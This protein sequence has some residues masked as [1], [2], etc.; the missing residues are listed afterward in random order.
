L[1]KLF[2]LFYRALGYQWEICSEKTI[3]RLGCFSRNVFAAAEENLVMCCF[4]RNVMC[5][6]LLGNVISVAKIFR[7]PRI[8]EE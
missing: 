1:V 8:A 2:L 5:H 3:D 4:E 7:Q 6:S